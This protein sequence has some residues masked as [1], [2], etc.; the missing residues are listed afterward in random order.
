ME[1]PALE[2]DGPRKKNHREDVKHCVVIGTIVAVIIT[3]GIL[4]G[5]GR[6][7]AASNDPPSSMTPLE[8]A[9]WDADVANINKIEAQ[10]QVSMAEI[11]VKAAAQLAPYM[12]RLRARAE[13][14]KVDLDQVGKTITIEESGKIIRKPAPA[15]PPQAKK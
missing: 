6:L 12:T 11:Q 10:A 7:F 13:K 9:Q 3:M 4:L 15:A 8:A 2:I 5:A 14:Y 1:K